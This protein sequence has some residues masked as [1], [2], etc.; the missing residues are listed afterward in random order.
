MIDHSLSSPIS[1]SI[2]V[3]RRGETKRPED[4]R[5]CEVYVVEEIRRE[6]KEGAKPVVIGHPLLRYDSAQLKRSILGFPKKILGEGELVLTDG[7]SVI[8]P[9]RITCES[10]LFNHRS[11][12]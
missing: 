2:Y 10:L 8:D 4:M 1:P 9:E 5:E 6:A 3:L 11:V 7:L 12:G